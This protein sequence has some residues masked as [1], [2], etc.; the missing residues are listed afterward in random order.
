MTTSPQ[1]LLPAA[2]G[3]APQKEV[4]VPSPNP[5]LKSTAASVSCRSFP[6]ARGRKHVCLPVYLPAGRVRARGG[7]AGL[8]VC[9]GEGEAVHEPG[10]AGRENRDRDG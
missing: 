5:E 4:G 10:P 6:G 9:G 8:L 7:R 3:H 2:V 1:T